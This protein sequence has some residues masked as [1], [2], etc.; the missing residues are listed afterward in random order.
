MIW[1]KITELVQGVRKGRLTATELV[2]QALR[3]VDAQQSYNAV[4]ALN[5]KA[6]EQ[7]QNIDRKV[8]SSQPMGPLSGVPYLAKDNYLTRNVETTAASNILKGFVPPFNATVIERLE[9]AGAILIG[10]TNMDAFAHGSSNE[11]SDFGPV[12]HPL[13]PKRVPGGSSGG[14]AA[15]V[16]LGMVPFALGTDTGGSIR[17]PASFCGV[18]GYKPTYG[19]VSRY[20]VVAM[21]SS[22]DVMGPITNCVE[23]AGV[24]IEIISG[25]DPLDSTTV[26]R[27]KQSYAEMRGSLKNARIGLVKEFISG[28]VEPEIIKRIQR[29]LQLLVKK[30]AIIQ[31]VSLPAAKE[32]LSIYYV[33]VP[34]EVSSNLSRYDGVRYG[35]R[36]AAI[37]LDSMYLGT[38]TRG[39]NSENR[40]RIIIGTYVLSS[41]YYEAY[42]QKA[43]QARTVLI[44]EFD[45]ALNDVDFL[46][47]P[48]TPT[49]AFKLGERSQDP[50]AMYMS[51]VLTVAPNLTGSPAISLPAG[52]DSKHLPIGLQIIAARGQDRQLLSFAKCC[53]KE[54]R[55]E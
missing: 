30:G 26:Q 15:A 19:L 28:G 7:A 12:K 39:F 11:N 42:Y 33:I 38:R 50:V 6:L 20:G 14:S 21:A 34:A 51:D 4:L 46:I 36:S 25:R 17:Q 37:D 43:Q 45:Q 54:M 5:D 49:T 22:T 9:Q 53:E 41:G 44:K 10:K 35:P 48:T 55:D 27:S 47:G 29:V 8:R 24:V 13:D 16:K 32:A 2:K 23:D 3:E 18:V 31:E 40:R 1:P 52:C